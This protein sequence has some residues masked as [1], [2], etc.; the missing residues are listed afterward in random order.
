MCP[1]IGSLY[2][3]CLSVAMTC[4]AFHA[5]AVSSR[6][7]G[8]TVPAR[9]CAFWPSVSGRRCWS[10]CWCSW[11]LRLRLQ[12]RQRRP[13]RP[14][15]WPGASRRAARGTSCRA[16]A[17]PGESAGGAARGP[18]RCPAAVGP[19]PERRRAA[20]CNDYPTG[21]DARIGE[22]RGRTRVNFAVGCLKGHFTCG[23]RKGCGSVQVRILGCTSTA[24][25]CC[26]VAQRSSFIWISVA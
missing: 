13:T 15:A 24:G 7:P 12:R 9:L 17:L 14:R 6:L 4:H 5:R 3:Q 1:R 18:R 26:S 23:L 22:R 25:H 20:R 21:R 8:V 16:R 10:S 2:V 11:R 19:A